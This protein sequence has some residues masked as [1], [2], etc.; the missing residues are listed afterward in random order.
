MIWKQNDFRVIKIVQ[1]TSWIFKHYENNLKSLRDSFRKYLRPLWSYESEFRFDRI[2]EEYFIDVTLHLFYVA[3]VVD[4]REI[5]VTEACWGKG[6]FIFLSD[7]C[8]PGFGL[9]E[10]L[11][12]IILCI[13]VMRRCFVSHVWFT[14]VW[15]YVYEYVIGVHMI[16]KI[17]VHIYDWITYAWEVCICCIS[18]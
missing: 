3:C 18:I 10:C 9:C 5:K 12:M 7:I 2:N 17:Y 4:F 14:Y 15:E 13:L 1:L 8:M 11:G 6:T 16:L